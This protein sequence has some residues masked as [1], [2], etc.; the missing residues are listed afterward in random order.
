M[1]KTD[2][3]DTQQRLDK[4]L[5]CA[6]F[7][8]TRSLATASIKNGRV[9]VNGERAKP[10]R[11]VQIDDTI[12]IE[13]P[14]YEQII[15]VLAIAQQRLSAPKAA[16]LYSESADSIQAREALSAKIKASRVVDERRFGKLSKKERRDREK[17]KRG[18]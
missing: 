18:I 15:T 4:W 13:K 7:F 6:R 12:R 1:I 9:S 8:K 3:T 11:I 17:F 16:A 14:P 2:N 10:A 5:W